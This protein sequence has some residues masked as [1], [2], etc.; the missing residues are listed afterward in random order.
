MTNM[1]VM[2]KLVDY[3]DK[4]YSDDNLCD[5]CKREKS[6]A[7]DINCLPKLLASFVVLLINIM[8]KLFSK[9]ITLMITMVIMMVIMMMIMIMPPKAACKLFSPPGGHQQ[10]EEVDFFFNMAMICSAQP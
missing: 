9:M 6:I 1:T 10:Q 3:H 2:T 8:M 5:F 4:D 7:V